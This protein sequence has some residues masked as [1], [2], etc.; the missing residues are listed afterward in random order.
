MTTQLPVREAQRRACPFRPAACHADGCM[1]WQPDPSDSTRGR[2]IMVAARL[3]ELVIVEAPPGHRA[4]T[5]TVVPL[6]GAAK[7]R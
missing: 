1:A 6:K 2:C 7:C 5:T 4:G 3:A